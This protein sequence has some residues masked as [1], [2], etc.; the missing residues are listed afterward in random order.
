MGMNGDKMT[1]PK[2]TMRQVSDKEM[3]EGM[4]KKTI[5][6]LKK[7][8]ANIKFASKNKMEI[9]GGTFSSIPIPLHLLARKLSKQDEYIISQMIAFIVNDAHAR[10][11]KTVQYINKM[12]KDHPQVKMILKNTNYAIKRGKEHKDILDKLWKR[13]DKIKKHEMFSLFLGI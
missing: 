3:F 2:I 13:K 4:S 9:F 5:D 10:C 1:K 12:P 8:V 7:D 6:R 11:A